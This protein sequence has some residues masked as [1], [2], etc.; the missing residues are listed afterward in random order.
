[1]GIEGRWEG[2]WR[3]E[4]TGHK[5]RLQCVIEPTE[6]EDYLAHYRAHYGGILSYSYA[7]P[8]RVHQEGNAVLFNGQADLGWLAGGV[9]TYEGTILHPADPPRATFYATYKARSDHG[10]FEMARPAE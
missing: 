2:E 10:V 3:S 5:G 8:M 4:K 1:M 9:Y 7:V 6:G